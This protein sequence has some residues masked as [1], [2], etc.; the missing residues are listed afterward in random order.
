[1]SIDYKLDAVLE[2]EIEQ[3]R[4]EKAEGHKEFRERLTMAEKDIEGLKVAIGKKVNWWWFF[5]VLLSIGAIQFTAWAAV[6]GEVRAIRDDG[7]Q[8]RNTVYQIKGQ[9]E[10]F[11]FILDNNK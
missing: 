9:L 8:T 4:Q 5:G 6:W 1:M 3:I 11:Q 7:E 10:P 2:R